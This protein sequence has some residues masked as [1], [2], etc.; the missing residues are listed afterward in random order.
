MSGRI[1]HLNENGEATPL[2]ET[3]YDSEKL[4]QELLAR[5]PDLLA[6]EQI[7][8]QEPRRWLLVSREMSVPGDEDGGGRWSLDHLFLD[9]DAVPTLVEV[10][11]ST[12]TR[13]RREILGQ[14]LD[15]AANAV[16]YWPVEEIRA[17]FESRCEQ[18]DED[19]EELL[20]ACL[21][22]DED[23]SD[24]WQGVKTNLQAGRVRMVFVADS[25]PAELS[26]VVEFLNKQMDPAEALAIEV[27]QFVGEGMKTLVPR[28]LGQT[29]A[30]RQRKSRK[31]GEQW[32]WESFMTA[33]RENKGEEAQ[34]VAEDILKWIEPEV[35]HI[36]WGS[37]AKIGG[38]VPMIECGKVE[39]HVCRMTTHGLF[40][41]RFDWLC[42][43][44]PF[45]DTA[46]KRELLAKINQIPGVHVDDNIAMKRISLGTLTKSATLE[47]L[48]EVLKWLI[49]KVKIECEG[50][51]S[52]E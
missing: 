23:A 45:S 29:E 44:R 16:A 37:G 51:P 35:S 9:Q 24:F 31:T 48:K 4:L 33:L 19:P 8:R 28:V 11:R 21:G 40:V 5:H 42:R 12:D 14:M 46:T 25:I 22:D 6:G 27:K 47:K 7:N 49:D 17:K 10:K 15:Y 26:T 3:K 43:R 30:A 18:N 34:K 1:F 41:F 32:T 39:Y 38:V 13:I 36:W 50:N 2:E 20:A 52:N